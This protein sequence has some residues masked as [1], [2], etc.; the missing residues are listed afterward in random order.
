MTNNFNEVEL[1]TQQPLETI[2]FRQSGELD[3]LI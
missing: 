2:D 3:G 1:K